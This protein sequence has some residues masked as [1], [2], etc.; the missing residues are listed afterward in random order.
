MDEGKSVDVVYLD[1]SKNGQ[2]LKQA[3]QGRSGVTVPGG[4]Q[5]TCNDIKEQG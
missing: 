4:V 3:H 1:F 2:A 5:E